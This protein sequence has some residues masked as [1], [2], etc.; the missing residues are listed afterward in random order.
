MK[1]FVTGTDTNIGK[2]IVCSWLALHTDHAYFKPIH[3]A[4]IL[5]QIVKL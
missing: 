4:L 2:T 1:V 5:Q 3:V